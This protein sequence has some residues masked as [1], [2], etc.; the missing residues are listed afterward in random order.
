MGSEFSSN[1]PGSFFLARGGPFDPFG[2]GGR[3]VSGRFEKIP[4]MP[5]Q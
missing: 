4:A 3:G 1:L 2:G 5:L